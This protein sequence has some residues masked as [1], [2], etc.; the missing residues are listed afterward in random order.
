MN[1]KLSKY[2]LPSWLKYP[3]AFFILLGL[4]MLLV[5]Y[6]YGIKLELFD[7]TSFTFYSVFIKVKSFEL[8]TNNLTE[9]FA[10]L[11]LFIGLVFIA[12]S[13]NK[14]DSKELRLKA[15]FIAMYIDIVLIV[16]TMFT[17]F[18]VPYI[19][20]MAFHLASF[21]IIYCIVYFSLYYR[22]KTRS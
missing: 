15:F 17:F 20:V 4:A 3:G 14:H 22:Q 6:Y 21:L 12:F 18:G 9:E 19:G 11:F 16:I 2:L 10:F 8:I 1:N 5:R 7:C 13:I